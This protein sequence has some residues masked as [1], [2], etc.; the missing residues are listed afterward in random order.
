MSR[1]AAVAP[2]R[3]LARSDATFPSALVRRSRCRRGYHQIGPRPFHRAPLVSCECRCFADRRCDARS[4]LYGTASQKFSSANREVVKAAD[5][6]ANCACQSGVG[7]GSGGRGSGRGGSSIGG[8]GAGLG[9]GCG[10]GGRCNFIC[11]RF[12]RLQTCQMP[13]KFRR[14]AAAKPSAT[15]PIISSLHEQGGPNRAQDFDSSRGH[16]RPYRPEFHW[17]LCRN[18][19]SG[20][21]HRPIIRRTEGGLGLAAPAASTRS[22]GVGRLSANGVTTS[23]VNITTRITATTPTAATTAD[24]SRAWHRRKAGPCPFLLRRLA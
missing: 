21:G 1:P 15:A 4:L 24:F 8:G 12:M 5:E 9:S 18:H 2:E 22:T 20:T 14:D 23:G 11:L 3:R 16:N 17:R 10:L 13:P 19:G 7:I 6:G